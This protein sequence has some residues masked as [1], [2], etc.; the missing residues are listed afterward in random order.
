M[1]YKLH[2]MTFK[3]EIKLSNGNI[4][5]STQKARQKGIFMDGSLSMKNVISADHLR[6]SY[7]FN[8]AK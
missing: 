8:K 4:A 5:P 6:M 3:A 2:L 7:A 1:T